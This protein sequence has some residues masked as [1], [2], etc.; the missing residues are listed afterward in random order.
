MSAQIAPSLA[1]IAGAVA[2]MGPATAGINR[3]ITGKVRRANSAA[4][5]LAAPHGPRRDPGLPS[6]PPQRPY[7]TFPPDAR[8]NGAHRSLCPPQPRKMYMDPWKH[9]MMARDEAITHFHTEV[10]AQR[11]AD[12]AE[13]EAAKG[14]AQ[15]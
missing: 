3:M 6:G 4:H 14:E 10:E 12:E 1:I 7:C 9:R 8:I 13:A 5:G 2:V 15:A 11:L